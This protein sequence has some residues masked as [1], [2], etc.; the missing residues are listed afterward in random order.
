MVKA[1]HS[2]YDGIKHNPWNEVEC[3]DH[4]VRAMASYGVL[5]AIQDY[6]YDGPKGVMGF[7][8]KIGADHFKGFFTS[9]EGWGNI[10][11]TRKTDCQENAVEVKYGRLTLSCLHLS[12]VSPDRLQTVKVFANGE[13]IRSSFRVAGGVEISFD[14]QE[15]NVG[16]RLTV[17]LSP[18]GS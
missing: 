1:L 14:P 9:A 13:E 6:W 11:Q 2:R 10:S 17:I 12:V 8:S 7:A 4:Y 15:L 3:G 16:D 5:T 18:S